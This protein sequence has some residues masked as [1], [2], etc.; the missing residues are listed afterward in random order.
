MLE[1]RNTSQDTIHE[2]QFHL[3][4]NAFRNENSTYFLE[5]GGPPEFIKGRWGYC[6]IVKMNLSDG[7]NLLPFLSY[8]HP[9]DDNIYDRTV[10]SIALPKPIL[11][12]ETI[13]IDIDFETKLPPVVAR[14]G[15]EK[16]YF[17]VTQ[18]FPKIGVYEEGAW[19]CHQYHTL[20]E[21]YA[22]FG[23]YDVSI[24]LPENYVVG[25]SG[26]LVDEKKIKGGLKKL[27]FYCEDIHDFAWCADVDFVE[28][29]DRYEDT[30]I[31]LLIQKDH[32]SMAN[33]FIKII[34]VV[35]D[36]Y[37]EKY[38]EYPY[39]MITIIDSKHV[40]AGEMEYPT[41]FQTGNFGVSLSVHKYRSDPFPESDRFIEWLT[42][43]E[44]G[45]NWWYGMV[46]NNEAEYAWLDEGINNYATAKA[47]EYGFDGNM[48]HN[49]NGITQSVRERDRRRYLDNPSS[50]VVMQYSWLFR[51]WNE[52][53]TMVY[54]KPELML[55]TLN[56]YFGDEIWGNV[57]K[58]YFQRWQ[59]K[60]P[61]PEDFY[62]VVHEITSKDFKYFFNQFLNTTHTLDFEIYKV[63]DNRVHLLKNGFLRFPVTI[64]FY[65]SDGSNQLIEWDNVINS[66][67]FD[68]TGR[69]D[70]DSVVIDPNHIVEFELNREN[71]IWINAK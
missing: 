49:H 33:R 58:A 42:I 39:P 45:H 23:V 56:N 40:D 66:A 50:A 71:N 52:Y 1:W 8:I 28:T 9:D 46:A 64:A 36:Y 18:W 30:K 27:R 41:L 48:L 51:Y 25:A 69:A 22:D 70:L 21:F 35:F 47:M 3:Y 6:E 61:K 10:C 16:N 17:S 12:N 43:H 60:H 19:I 62:K 63:N 67:V 37:G 2:L 32:T 7:T 57:M 44:F 14:S 26:I 65:F 24:T 4:Q 54:H 5:S 11:P 53:Y 38:G 68:M 55:L 15:Y 29:L 59:F 13:K 34:K 20:G 31:R